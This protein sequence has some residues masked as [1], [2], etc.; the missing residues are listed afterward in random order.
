MDDQRTDRERSRL[1]LRQFG[2]LCYGSSAL[3]LIGNG[4]VERNYWNIA[5]GILMVPWAIIFLRDVFK[6]NF[7]TT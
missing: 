6:N 3:Y 1:A 4:F 5:I 2:A 7:P